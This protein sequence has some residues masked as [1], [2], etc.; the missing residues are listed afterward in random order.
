MQG[1]PQT[2]EMLPGPFQQ[3]A[4][5]APCMAGCIGAGGCVYE[6][7]QRETDLRLAQGNR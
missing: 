5:E 1:L 7:I 2:D 6:D 3:K 4:G